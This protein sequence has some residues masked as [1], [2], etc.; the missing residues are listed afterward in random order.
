MP[1]T[2]LESRTGKNN[3]T[4][5][6]VQVDQTTTVNVTTNNSRLYTHTDGVTYEYVGDNGANR[7]YRDQRRART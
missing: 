4:K 6:G 5:P 2:N 1:N 7:V 3:V